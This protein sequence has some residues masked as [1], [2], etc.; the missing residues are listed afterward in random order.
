[1]NSPIVGV[2][3][4]ADHHMLV[5]D[6]HGRPVVRGIQ[7]TVDVWTLS[8]ILAAFVILSLGYLQFIGY[9]NAHPI[10]LTVNVEPTPVNPAM[11]VQ[12][13]LP[14]PR[15]LVKIVTITPPV[16]VAPNVEDESQP[17]LRLPN[18]TVIPHSLQEPMAQNDPH[19]VIP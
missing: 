5:V 12:N 4:L 3:N 17:N 6:E 9:K 8:I 16:T 13:I 19:V 14:K 15:V 7:V 2:G 11:S 18:V 10:P 1:M